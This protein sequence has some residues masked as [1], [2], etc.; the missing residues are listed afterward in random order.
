MWLNG[1]RSEGEMAGLHSVEIRFCGTEKPS[2]SGIEFRRPRPTNQKHI[3][4]PR[5]G[6]LREVQLLA[7][8]IL[9]DNRQ[10]Y[11]GFGRGKA[12]HKQLEVF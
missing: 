9:K 3:D 10:K 2:T 1:I 8:G 12:Q 7:R 11:D 5:G 6:L 4:S